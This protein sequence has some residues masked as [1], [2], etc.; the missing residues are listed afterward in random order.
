MA[1]N[2]TKTGGGSRKGKPN[3]ATMG[4]RELARGFVD[5]P[6]YRAALKARLEAGTAGSM[7]QLLWQFAYGKPLAL[8]EDG[9]SL[10]VDIT[11]TF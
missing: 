2:G 11:I 7:E 1:R 6:V 3:K 9:R 10:P 5:D 8:S 4:I